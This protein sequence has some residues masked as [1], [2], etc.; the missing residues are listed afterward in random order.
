MELGLLGSVEVRAGGAGLALGGRQQRLVLAALAV[1]VGRVV[2]R[3][4][5]IDRVW[6]EAPPGEVEAAVYA[7]VS[8]LRGLLARVNA[9]EDR[10][11]PVRLDRLPGGYV[12]RA[13]PDEVDL[14]RFRRLVARARDP[15]STIDQR[16]GLLRDALALWRGEPLAGLPGSW[17]ARTRDAW[18]QQYLDAVVAWA[19]AEVRAGRAQ[20]VVG[21][22]RELTGEHPLVEPLAAVL[23]R[24]LHATGRSTDALALYAT[25]RQRIADELGA[26][27]GSDLQVIHQAILRG[28]LDIPPQ[29]ITMPATATTAPETAT[30]VPAQPPT[31]VVP[32]QLPAAVAG[33]AGRADQLARLD[34][35]LATAGTNGHTAAPAAVV[36]SAVSGTAGVGKTALAVQWAHRVADQFPDGQLY[37]N[38]RG[39]DPTGEPMPPAQ[40]VRGFLDA[41]GVPPQRI[42]TDLD[43][44][45]GLYRSQIAGKRML[46][47]LDNARDAAQVRPL[48]PGASTALAVVTSR[49]QLTALVA[50][51][52]AHPLSL[53]VLTVAEAHDLLA[54]RLGAERVAAEPD[55]VAQIIAACARLPLA[56]AIAAARAQQ[57]N[58]PLAA[59][60]ADLAADLG[61]AGRRLDALDAGDPTT[62]ARAVFSWSYTALTPPA[63]RLFRLLGLHPG[64]DIS[65]PAAASLAGQP[66]R[67]TS[68][69]LTELA[70]AN[71]ITQR[72]PGR[73][74]LHDLLRAYATDLAHTHD[75]DPQRHAATHRL[76]DHYL[77]TAYTAD[78][79]L[80]PARDPITLTPPQPG[81]TPEHPTDHRQAL[82]W[83]TAEHP[84]LLATI[85]HAATTGFDTHTW[86]L[87]WTIVH[88]LYWRGHWHEQAAAGRTAVAA[89]ERLADP[90]VQGRGHRILALAYTMLGRLDDAHTELSQALEL[91]TQAGDQ[92][93]QAQTHVVLG[94]VWERHGRY[95]EALHHAQQAV[96]L[97]RATGHQAGQALALNAVGRSHALLGDYQ[98]ALTAC[99][100]ALT[101]HQDLG[102]RHG[103]AASW[104]S[105]G[106]AHHHLGH[107]TQAIT[108][109]HHAV[110]LSR[111]FGDRYGE[112][113][114]LTHLGDTHQAAGDVDAA[115][116][117]YQQ[118]LTILTDLDH[119]DAQHLRTKLHQLN[120]PAT[121]PTP[122]GQHHQP[123]V[124]PESGC[125]S[126][127]VAWASPGSAHRSEEPWRR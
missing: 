94:Q 91:A 58:F 3:Q 92:A 39:F 54:H 64:P 29:P 83:F 24:A 43:A 31:V 56:L 18:R 37:V 13:E 35:L 47:V 100:Q 6:D 95:T 76:L 36:I 88:F 69:L 67:E 9:A 102:D 99:Q 33:F 46:V 21:P 105:L 10:V 49:N 114:T 61:Q 41:L 81:V 7:H 63:A 60:A 104:D 23:M 123:D 12:L 82:D 38:L 28:D 96:R 26:D 50:T 108:C 124:A 112:A 80:N 19:D 117:C 121:D 17:A 59:L 42:P 14:H 20:V 120:G 1:D 78:R 68:R 115:R 45:T 15:A 93:V 87:T 103:Q 77:H 32:A 34:K 84:V 65:T 110:E 66:P 106:Y 44:Q 75:T 113:D 11:V 52:A 5:L 4:A 8:R 74:T 116:Q 125:G 127:G 98:Q 89:A 2:V 57:T 101:L 122:S 25:L 79:L 30:T 55:A 22:L 107:H 119:T 85:N 73:Y 118:A 126:S 53:D 97:Y 62:Q 16:A 90:A 86:Q 72:T 109:Y 40:A 51:D 48:L 111:D 70:S 71:L 27:P